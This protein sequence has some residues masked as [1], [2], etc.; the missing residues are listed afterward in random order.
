MK[1]IVFYFCLIV[2]LSQAIAATIPD[3][4]REITITGKRTPS[5]K[6]QS[7]AQLTFFMPDEIKSAR[8]IDAGGQERGITVLQ[9]HGSRISIFFDGSPGEELSIEFYRSTENSKTAKQIS[10]LLHLVKRFNSDT[11]VN[12]VEDFRKLWNASGPAV[13]GFA[14]KVFSGVNPYSQSMN[15]LH[16]YKGFINIPDG[17]DYI[18]YTASTDASFLLIDNKVI[19]AWPGKHWVGEGLYGGYNGTVKLTKGIH[20][21]EYLHANSQW[22]CYAIAAYSRRDDKSM[23]IIPDKMFTPA[24][25]AVHGPLLDMHGRPLLDFSWEN[26]AM[27]DL[28][29]LQMYRIVCKPENVSGQAKWNWG[30]NTQPLNNRSVHYYFIPGKY[31]AALITDNERSNQQIEVTYRFDQQFIPDEAAVKMVTE[32]IEQEKTIGIQREGYTFITNAIIQLKMGGQALGFYPRILEKSN[33]IPPEV[34]L[35][36]F[37]ELILMELLKLE[38]YEKAEEEF[39]RFFLQ[40]KNQKCLAMAK[41]EYARMLFYCMG[42]NVDAELQLNEIDRKFIPFESKQGFD[43]LQ[44]DLALFSKGIEEASQLYD[45]LTSMS[46]KLDRQQKIML[47]GI[48]ISI[49][50]S[51]TMKRYDDALNYIEQLENSQAESRLN[52]EVILMKAQALK[53]LGMPRRAVVCYTTVLKLNPSAGTAAPANLALAEYYCS[54]MQYR[55]AREYLNNIISETPRSHEAVPAGKILKEIA[56]KEDKNEK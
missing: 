17:G 30:D 35:K 42:R 10:G 23:T 24:L 40:N 41:L 4:Y 33:L 52:P 11:T 29:R 50:N 15:S 22:S 12:N 31:S 34:I 26:E 43:I 8:L 46:K 5:D 55:K 18:F 39:K 6:S 21:F 1:Y 14:K 28:E 54:S 25:E 16:T 53:N 7:S 48:I 44:A 49:R 13:G 3:S 47:S 9:R 56:R 32:A 20:Q 38:K 19:A 27:L 36:Y 37:Q 45:Q 51:I 2:A